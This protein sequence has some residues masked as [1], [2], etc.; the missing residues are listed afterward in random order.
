MIFIRK[1][2]AFLLTLTLASLLIFFTLYALP[3]DPASM[4]LGMEASEEMI[5]AFREKHG[6]NKSFFHQYFFWIETLL[7]GDLGTSFSYQISN[8]DLIQERLNVTIP[9][10]L[11]SILLS[12]II[13]IPVGFYAAIH[14]KKPI[15]HS[16]MSWC[17]IGIALPS[18]WIGLLLILIFSIYL[19]LLPAGRF[20]GWETGILISFKS[21]ILPTVALAIPEAAILSRLARSTALELIH[22]HYVRTAKAKGLSNFKVMKNHILRNALI[23]IV[24]LIGMQFSYL[25]TGTI[26]IEN[27]F[28]LPGLG[29]LL[30]QAISQRDYL[31]VCN[32]VLIFVTTISFIN[33]IID[34]LYSK[35]DPRLKKQLKEKRSVG[36]Y[37]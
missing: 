14:H 9:L 20:P 6:L 31:L 22:A 12:V 37:A 7:K 2:F 27:V 13:A 21:L 33:F 24:T 23:P 5:E 3:G 16:I 10:A 19:K 34:L 26:I 30:F 28:D 35:I 15:D 1:I 18:F 32:L 36:Y 25:L 29:K 11:L 8:A 17:H 4:I